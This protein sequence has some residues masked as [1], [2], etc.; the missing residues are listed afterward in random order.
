MKQA[1]RPPDAPPGSWAGD[2]PIAVRCACGHAFLSPRQQRHPCPY[3]GRTCDTMETAPMSRDAV[4]RLKQRVQQAWARRQR[5]WPPAPDLP[6]PWPTGSVPYPET[7]SPRLLQAIQGV[8][9]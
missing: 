4:A 6:T 7:P 1:V 5:E 8:R 9:L 2:H 3:C